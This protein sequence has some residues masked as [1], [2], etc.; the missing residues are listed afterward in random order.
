M[1]PGARPV[2]CASQCARRA[3]GRKRA[4]TRPYNAFCEPGTDQTKAS[5]A[6]RPAP[7]ARAYGA[8]IA[9]DY[10]VMVSTLAPV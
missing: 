10:P 2:R 7:G 5:R 9:L 8:R 1:M 4:Q 6:G 3:L